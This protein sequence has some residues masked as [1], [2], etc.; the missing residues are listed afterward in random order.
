MSEKVVANRR[1]AVSRRYERLK[2]SRREHMSQAI[3]QEFSNL[4]IYGNR[5]SA[6]RTLT[7]RPRE[8]VH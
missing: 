5:Y 4:P 6:R 1:A 3:L 8:V 2:A 7:R